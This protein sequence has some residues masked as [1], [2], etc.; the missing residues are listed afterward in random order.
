MGKVEEKD[1]LLLTTEMDVDVMM[2]GFIWI[3]V[4]IPMIG[5]NFLPM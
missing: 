2:P 4:L 3:L 1:V 5:C